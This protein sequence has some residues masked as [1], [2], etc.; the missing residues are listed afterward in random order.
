MPESMVWALAPSGVEDMF[1]S[2]SINS[3]L[4]E[5]GKR[6]EKKC[7]ATVICRQ[8]CPKTDQILDEKGMKKGFSSIIEMSSRMKGFE[9]G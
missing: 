3:W 2:S 4:R 8:P 6:R 5:T 1:W 9:K 7:F